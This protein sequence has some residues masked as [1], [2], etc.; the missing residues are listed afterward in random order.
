V[1]V[2]RV[3]LAAPPLPERAEGWALF[4]AAGAC[5]RK[6]RDQMEAWPAADRLEVVVAASQVRIATVVL[7]PMPPSRM[8]SAAAFALEDQLAGPNAA[9][10]VAV[11][12]RSREGQVRVAIV[13]RSLLD[14]IV[15][16]CPNVGRIVAECDLAVPANDWRWCAPLPAAA[17]FVRRPDGSAFP[18]DPPSADGA[19]PAELELALQQARRS[20]APAARVRVELP[21]EPSSA[22][23]LCARWARETG[24]E[25]IG[26]EPWQWEEAGSTAFAGAADLLPTRIESTKATRPVTP[27]RLFA[28]ALVLAAAALALHV[29]ASTI[30]WASLRLQ[31]WRDARE[32]TSLAATT[33][34]PAD[35]AA[36]P[37]TAR[38]ALAR[39]YAQARH[40]QGLFAPD[41]ALPLLARAVP[42]LATLPQGSVKRAA[43]ADGH[44]T[45]DLALANPAAI[46]DLELRMRN[47]GVPALM[48]SSPNGVRMRIGG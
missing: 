42:A 44:W 5:V 3:L 17:G 22:A 34:V 10:H 6:G 29:V 25:F 35:A 33:G 13:A 8:A 24:A 12:P 18:T 45:F 15:D 41:D 9:H 7:P 23:S 16:R 1:T 2:L 26:G 4:D 37:A 11:S 21:L 39:R 40:D 47:A 20:D 48:A 46:G 14:Q 38:L 19:L 43:Y 30:E 27:G 28:P 36:T 32:W 31:A